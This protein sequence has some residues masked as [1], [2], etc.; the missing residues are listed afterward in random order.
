VYACPDS[1]GRQASASRLSISVSIY[2]RPSRT[3]DEFLGPTGTNKGSE[4]GLIVPSTVYMARAVSPV[5][6]VLSAALKGR[7][8][9][10]YSS[11]QL[12][13]IIRHLPPSDKR[14]RLALPQPSA[15]G[16]AAHRFGAAASEG[17][18]GAST[19]SLGPVYR[20]LRA[21]IRRC[22]GLQRWRFP[23]SHSG[24]TCGA[25]GDRVTSIRVEPGS[26]S[27]EL[28]KA[29]RPAPW[30]EGFD[31]RI[32]RTAPVAPL[33]L[34]CHSSSWQPSPF[35]N[36]S[37]CPQEGG[38]LA[39]CLAALP[40]CLRSAIATKARTANSIVPTMLTAT[41]CDCQPL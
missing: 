19:P 29:Q 18:G 15:S 27:S 16:S 40:S 12:R 21:V 2:S 32:S 17:G 9:A 3:A 4:R 35:G 37:C 31:N 14:R 36:S 39:G 30:S 11:C 26:C 23:P 38:P 20:L 34:L 41:G 1:T 7:K 33:E 8:P 5:V 25:Q 22:N 28:P 6:A 13:L 24:P 10:C